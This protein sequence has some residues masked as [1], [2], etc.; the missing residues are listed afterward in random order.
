MIR[1]LANETSRIAGPGRKTGE[2]RA[3]P[4]SLQQCAACCGS[5]E[6]WTTRSAGATI[7]PLPVEAKRALLK[8]QRDRSDTATTVFSTV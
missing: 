8:P 6:L 5:W 7:P 2:L 3:A 4:G 1:H